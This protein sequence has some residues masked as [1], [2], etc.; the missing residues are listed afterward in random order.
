[1]QPLRRR[2]D[3]AVTEES[4]FN[5]VTPYGESKVMAEQRIGQFADDDFS[6][7]Y[8]RNATAYGSSPRL[9]ADIVVNNLTGAALTRAR[10]G[11]RATARRG[12]RWS[13]PRTSRGRSSRC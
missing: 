9:R 10:S 11:C 3:G 1:M 8:L 7:M 4:D 2:G 13:T 5:P 6:P 12:A